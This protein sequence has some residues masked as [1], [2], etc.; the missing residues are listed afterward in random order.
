M[1]N[2]LNNIVGPIPDRASRYS[3][4]GMFTLVNAQQQYKTWPRP[5]GKLDMDRMKNAKNFTY[6]GLLQTNLV[7]GGVV[8]N[9][10]ETS[11]EGVFISPDG[12]NFYVTGYNAD[13]VTQY[14]LLTPF[15]L[16]SADIDNATVYSILATTPSV[17]SVTFSPDGYYMYTTDAI[18]PASVKQYTLTVPWSLAAENVSF[19]ASFDVSGQEAAPTGVR[20]NPDGTVM[21][22]CGSSGDGLDQYVLNTPWMLAD[23]Y[24][25][26]AFGDFNNDGGPEG[27]CFNSTGDKVY[28]I[29]A[30]EIIYQH[31]LGTAWDVTSIVT[32]ADNTLD[33]DAYYATISSTAT[34]DVLLSPDDSVMYVTDAVN[35][36][37]YSFHLT[38]PGD[39]STSSVKRLT[40]KSINPLLG[41]IVEMAWKP[42]GTKVYTINGSGD[43][44]VE[45]TLSTPWEINTAVETARQGIGGTDTSPQGITISQDGSTI[46]TVGAANDRIYQWNMPNAWDLASGNITLTGYVSYTTAEAYAASVSFNHDGTILYIT[47]TT[48]D[49]ITSFPLSTPWDALSLVNTNFTQYT[50]NIPGPRGFFFSPDG[51]GLFILNHVNGGDTYLKEYQLLEPY[52]FEGSYLIKQRLMNELCPNM[53]AISRNADGSAFYA[54]FVANETDELVQFDLE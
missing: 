1:S 37:V 9:G 48:S 13:A 20:F 54:G 45:Y 41:W 29:G 44:L 27:F 12:L 11:A 15:D 53:L 6:G 14:P 36:F 43:N 32:P 17:R 40:T 3:T 50:F 34:N 21:Y 47:G 25:S 16:G 23:G 26:T 22:I 5:A 33:F 31:S 39:I 38:T 8:A 28:M 35:N 4:P 42:D 2:K 51:L 49:G 18:A 52:T 10:A 30:N 7:A 24:S 19:T 46:V